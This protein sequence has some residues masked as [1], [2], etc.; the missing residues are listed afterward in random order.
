MKKAFF[1]LAIAAIVFTS[2]GIGHTSVPAT[3]DT[4]AT[5]TSTVTPTDTTHSTSVHTVTSTDTSHK[6]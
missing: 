4:T 1:A 5:V 3:V 6:K 2:C